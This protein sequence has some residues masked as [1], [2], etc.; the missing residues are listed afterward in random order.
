MNKKLK[1]AATAIAIIAGAI[2]LNNTNLLAEHHGGK[3]V[4][5]AHRGMAQRFDERDLKNDTCTAAR[6]LPPTHEYQE[7]TISSMRASFAAGADIVELDVH[8][9]TDGEFAVFH[10][11]TLDCRTDGHGVTREH[12][13]AYLKKLDI[14]HGYTADGGKTFPFRGKGIGQMPTLTEVLTTFPQARLLIN[15]KSRDASEGEKLA[16]ALAKLP[17]ERRTQIMV[18]GG[19]EPVEAVR[20]RLPEIRTISRASIKSCL[21]GYIGYG[22]TGLLPKA[23]S[24]AMVMV[25]INVAPWMWGWPDRF[26]N[27][28]KVANS[29]VFVLGSYRGGGFSSGIDTSEQFARL[30]QNFSGGIW[31]NEIEVIAPLVRR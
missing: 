3:S 11:W 28:M 13:M 17:A 29:E 16:A 9:T 31:T 4:L 25:P 24:N 1:Y 6:M 20:K 27:R 7:N 22:W 18:Y 14:A 21:L 5:L 8:P 12:S 23:C 2:Y 10:D 15:V 19:D 26:I 30:P